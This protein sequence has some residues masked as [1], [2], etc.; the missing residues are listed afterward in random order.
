MKR[1]DRWFR[2]SSGLALSLLFLMALPGC[3]KPFIQVTVD[4][5]CGPEGDKEDPPTGPMTTPCNWNG[6][7]CTHKPKGCVCLK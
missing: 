4:A 5:K 2:M 7:T 3:T 6:N 1:E